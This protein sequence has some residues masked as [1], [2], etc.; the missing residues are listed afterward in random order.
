MCIV[1]VEKSSPTTIA[2]RLGNNLV[3]Y[4]VSRPITGWCWHIKHGVLMIFAKTDPDPCAPYMYEVRQVIDDIG[5]PN[6]IMINH[7]L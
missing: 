4:H 2:A 7:E 3:R 1:E 6:C 5:L